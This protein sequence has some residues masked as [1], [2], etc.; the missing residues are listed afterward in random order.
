MHQLST[1][2]HTAYEKIRDQIL[3]GTLTGGTKLIEERLAEEI[4]VSR[5]PIRE[6]IRRLESEGLIQKKKVYKPSRLDLIHL[7]EMRT[8]LECYSVEKASKYMTEEELMYLKQCIDLARQSEGE[9]VVKANKAFHDAIV[10][11][12]RNP[13]MIAEVDKM[14]SIIYMFSR[15]VVFNKRPLLIDEHE[16][17]YNAIAA[18][19]GV[20]ASELVRKHLETDLQFT[21][22]LPENL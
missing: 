7:F 21:L 10:I 3:N 1:N 4:G 2:A 9:D 17:I 5:T 18:R 8:L 13:L 16:E 19:N 22:N 6:A 20:L 11:Q 12:C 15:A 14:K